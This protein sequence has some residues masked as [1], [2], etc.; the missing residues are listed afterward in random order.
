[1]ASTPIGR[2]SAPVTLHGAVPPVPAVLAIL[3]R[4]NRD[5]LG[6]TIEVLVA[7][8]DIWDG[9]PDLEDDDPAEAAGDEQDA[10]YVEWHTKPSNSRRSGQPEILASDNEDDE[11]DDPAEEDDEPGQ[12]TE[13]ELSSG[14]YAYGWH[15]YGP[16][17]EIADAGEPEH[18]AEREQMLNDVPALPVF[19]AERNIFNDRR[20]MLGVGNLQSSFRTNGAEVR[21]ADSGAIL[22]TTAIDAPRQ[23]GSPV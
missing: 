3:N 1:M 7:L 10:A 20:T 17:C 16:G 13:D 11:E 19:T 14:K 18:D 9:E 8:L 4:F 5:E 12:N 15:D 2:D 23:P 21:S 6:N 22:I